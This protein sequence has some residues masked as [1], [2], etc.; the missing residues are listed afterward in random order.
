MERY[1]A[2]MEL[3][4]SIK[5][6]E[7]EGAEWEEIDS[8]TWRKLREVFGD[9][10]EMAVVYRN[11]HLGHL[12]EGW[13]P[14]CRCGFALYNP[15]KPGVVTLGLEVRGEGEF[16]ASLCCGRCQEVVGHGGMFSVSLNIGAGEF[17][18]P[19]GTTAGRT[20]WSKFTWS[21]AVAEVADRFLRRKATIGE[22]RAA[23]K[24]AKS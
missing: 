7:E 14:L 17:T 16:G 15:R 1:L 8:L 10:S 5:E 13:I 22:L 4:S 12:R 6:K 18:A 11:S 9:D 20:E 3:I 2:L 24:A 23:V 19:V 21:P